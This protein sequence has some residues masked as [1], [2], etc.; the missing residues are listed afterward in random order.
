MS[1]SANTMVVTAAVEPGVMLGAAARP[2]RRSPLLRRD[3]SERDTL[4][5][6]DSAFGCPCCCC[7]CCCDIVCGDT[8]NCCKVNTACV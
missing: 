6:A 1:A 3:L 2:K 8:N 4:A 7:C 5:E